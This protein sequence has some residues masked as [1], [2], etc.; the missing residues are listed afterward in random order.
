MSKS[1]RHRPNI[2][3]VKILSNMDI[4]IENCNKHITSKNQSDWSVRLLS[5]K[6][7]LKLIPLWNAIRPQT[8]GNYNTVYLFNWIPTITREWNQNLEIHTMNF[9]LKH[10]QTGMERFYIP[11]YPGLKFL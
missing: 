10:L 9:S 4:K 2:V 1:R 7:Y 6:L 8:Q 5:A 11:K 3:S